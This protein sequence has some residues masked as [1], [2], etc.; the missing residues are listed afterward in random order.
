MRK[1]TLVA[2]L[3]LTA[4]T[5]F[6]DSKF[7]NWTL[8]GSETTLENY[9]CWRSYTGTTESSLSNQV[10]TTSD[11]EQVVTGYGAAGYSM[12]S[13]IKKTGANGWTKTLSAAEI[14][15]VVADNAGGVY[16]TGNFGTTLSIGDQTLKGYADPEGSYNHCT[17]FVAHYDK[18]GNVLAAKAIAPVINEDVKAKYE[19]YGKQGNSVYCTSSKI[20]LDGTTPYVVLNFTDKLTSA[21]G[22]KTVVSGN[23]AYDYYGMVAAGSTRS[24][25]VA[26]LDAETLGIKDFV[27]TAKGNDFSDATN[28][29]TD[30]TSAAVTISDG[31][32]YAAAT[33]KGNGCANGN[34]QGLK[35]DLLPLDITCSGGSSKATVMVSENL[36][37]Y[38][39]SRKLFNGTY[40]WNVDGKG[41]NLVKDLHCVGNNL[42]LVGTS[43]GTSLF[44]EEK[45]TVGNTDV[46]VARLAK[47]SSFGVYWVALSGVAEGDGN[48]EKVTASTVSGDMIYV[49]AYTGNEPNPSYVKLSKP[50]FWAFNYKRGATESI[51]S[52]EY[53]T[54]LAAGS[55]ANQL[56]ISSYKNETDALNF[57]LYTSTATSISSAKADKVQD[58]K[59]YNLQGQ[60]LA[61]P[62]KGQIN[63]VNGK[64]V[65][66]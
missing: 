25:T 38:A 31:V 57:G 17:A 35:T 54:G 50:Y 33:F 2:S 28:Y 24:V 10:V 12:Q 64:K 18:A 13:L 62:V 23:Y 56:Y 66:F 52:T 42:Y 58:T 51:A 15:S 49:S 29:G 36:S 39:F 45:K 46:F 4:M 47:S 34:V 5:T 26:Q 55:A 27:F 44:D 14:T 19:Y 63:I 40:D 53:V 61:A 32:L 16:V 20:L 48:V 1:F 59:I 30:V 11:G 3:L 21:D 41:D 60:R 9:A 7:G 43:T 65:I 22:E 8:N 37:T 6:A